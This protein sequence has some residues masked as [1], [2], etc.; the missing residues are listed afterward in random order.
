MTGTRAAPD[1]ANR[2]P[3]CGGRT[4]VPTETV[5]VAWLAEV[6]STYRLAHRIRPADGRGLAEHVA[7]LTPV[8]R[9]AIVAAIG[10]ESIRFDRCAGCGLEAASP[11]RCWPEG[12]YPNDENYPLR[13]E[14]GRF[15]D[16]LGPAPLEVLE[17]GSG[18]GQFLRLAGDRGHRAVGMDFSPGAVAVARA[19]GLEVLLGGF[20]RLREHLAD[21]PRQVFDAVAIFHVIEHLPDP[22]EVF[23]RL[24]EFVRPGTRLALSC[25]GPNR[26]TDL[27]GV[28]QVGSR[29]FWDYPPHH[30]LRWTLP[31]LRAFLAGR[32]WD[33]T[34]GVEEPLERRGAAAQIGTTR[35]MWKGYAHRRWR[36]RLSILAARL[37]LRLVRRAGL[38]LYA[39]AVYRG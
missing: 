23:G 9:A 11:R 30:V 33:M 4:L 22:A 8:T 32:G 35:A 24:A 27:I 17:L 25:P 2:C 39:L 19:S 10:A 1:P 18:Q 12:S 16:D 15:L 34:V 28:Q 36:T 20:G 26:Y 37:R 7:E 31:A 13:W 6:F 5:S 38:S 21:R 3:A 29:D 14:F